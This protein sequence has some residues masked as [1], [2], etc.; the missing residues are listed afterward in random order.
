MYLDWA[1]GSGNTWCAL[2]YLDLTSIRVSGV[3]IIS[4]PGAGPSSVVRVGQGDIASCLA[5][6]RADP[7]VR[8]HGPGLVVAWAA[9]EPLYAGGVEVYLAQQLRP[10]VGE[11]Y[12]LSPA[13]EV[14][15]PTSA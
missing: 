1:K 14:N 3:F 9:V 7:N 11:R 2:D 15:L 8:R 12:P 10:F 4:K 13:V 5:R 6:H